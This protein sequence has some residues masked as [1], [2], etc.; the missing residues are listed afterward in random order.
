MLTNNSIIRLNVWR[1]WAMQNPQSLKIQYSIHTTMTLLL[2]LYFMNKLRWSI[3]IGGVA[4]SSL[5][6][7]WNYTTHQMHNRFYYYYNRNACV[8]LWINL[9]SLSLS[10]TCFPSNYREVCCVWLIFFSVSRFV[11]F[12]FIAIFTVVICTAFFSLIFL[13]HGSVHFQSDIFFFFF[14][15]ISSNFASLLL[16]LIFKHSFYIIVC[17]FV[18]FIDF[19]RNVFIFVFLYSIYTFTLYFFF[20]NWK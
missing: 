18:L 14:F 6:W 12:I 10:L 2:L 20:H 11:R 1:K 16:L 5:L 15:F 9:S 17:V 19:N 4:I 3:A 7:N 8:P 13:L